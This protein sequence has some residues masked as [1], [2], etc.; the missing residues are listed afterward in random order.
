MET[1]SA[2][3]ALC[4]G[5]HRSPADS[6]HKGQ[7]RG[8]M[9][10]L[11]CDWMNGWVNNRETGDLRRNRVHYDVIVRRRRYRNIVWTLYIE[12]TSNHPFKSFNIIITVYKRWQMRA[13]SVKIYYNNNTQHIVKQWLRDAHSRTRNVFEIRKERNRTSLANRCWREFEPTFKNQEHGSHINCH[14]VTTG[15]YLFL[16]NQS[17][18]AP[19]NPLSITSVA[20]L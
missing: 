9:F 13:L 2:L 7:W 11:I 6:P 4:R 19:R 10:S 15:F 5:I 3:L 1:F 20:H 14:I 16:T 18:M 8:I 17:K 12:S